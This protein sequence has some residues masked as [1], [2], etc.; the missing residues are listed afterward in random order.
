MP[1]R[2]TSRRGLA[3]VWDLFEDGTAKVRLHK[4]SDILSNTLGA[5]VRISTSVD[6]ETFLQAV[7][8]TS[9]SFL[10]VNTALKGFSVSK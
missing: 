6:T 9:I 1:I 2:S 7:V 10:Y 8:K 3:H 5:E 4:I